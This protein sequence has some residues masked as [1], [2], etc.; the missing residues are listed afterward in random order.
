VPA[1]SASQGGFQQV[2]A[3]IAGKQLMFQWS[4]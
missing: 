1:V 3:V 2:Y 4:L